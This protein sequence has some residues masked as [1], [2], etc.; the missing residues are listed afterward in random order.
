MFGY[1]AQ[2]QI[3]PLIHSAISASSPACPSFST[4]TADMIWPGVQ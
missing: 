2:R 4:A 3:L 1:A